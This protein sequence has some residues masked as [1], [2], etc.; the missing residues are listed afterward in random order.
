MSI[1]LVCCMI[2]TAGWLA[3]S[4]LGRVQT[5]GGKDS[6]QNFSRALDAI[7]PGSKRAGARRPVAT[8]SRRQA[9]TTSRRARDQ[10]TRR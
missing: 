9:R 7:S 10:L 6:V 4:L 5:S 2:A 1:F 8:R 3:I